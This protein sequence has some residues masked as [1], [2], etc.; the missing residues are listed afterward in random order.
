MKRWMSAV[1]AAAVL[2]GA[3]DGAF[4]ASSFRTQIR[5]Y[6]KVRVEEI[7]WGAERPARRYVGRLDPPWLTRDP[8]RVEVIEFVRHTGYTWKRSR[9]LTEAWEKS[10]PEGVVVR[11]MAKGV[12][13]GKGHRLAKEWEVQQELLCTAQQM[14]LG[15]EAHVWLGRMANDYG[16][17]RPERTDKFVARIGA[18]AAEFARWRA[19]A[20]TAECVVGVSDMHW[21]VMW[22]DEHAGAPSSRPGYAPDFVVN[23]RYSVS[24]SWVPNPANVYR[25]VN[26]LIRLELE[27]IEAEGASHDGPT[28][29]A[30]LAAWLAPRSGEVFSRVRFGKRIRFK[31]VYSADRREIWGLND[32]GS[33]KDTSPLRGE[34]DDSYWHFVDPEKGERHLHLWMRALQY[35]SYETAE[36]GPQRYGAF[37]LTDW[38][39][40]PETLWVGLPFKGREVAMAFTPDGKVEARNDSGSLFGTW[41][42]EAGNLNVS[43]GELGIQSWPWQE[44]AAHVGFE[45]PRESLVPWAVE[46]EREK[47]AKA[48]RAEKRKKMQRG[49]SAA[50]DG[51]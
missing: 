1:I 8:A 37:L 17:A 31:G 32:D 42:L 43:F 28:N 16:L 39:S 33:F 41:W 46:A 50:G 13:S 15:K 49:R 40:A 21:D 11:R 20:E 34:G 3:A 22:A 29:D 10:L 9:R 7:A 47:V 4:G 45:V 23:G 36:G 44:A 38:L 12:G 27:R 14:G 51:K 24:A 2:G 26:R 18:D 48:A 6:D 5:K 35:V 25:M 19:R 30:E